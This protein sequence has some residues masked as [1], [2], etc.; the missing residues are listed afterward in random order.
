[1]PLNEE[2]IINN[3]YIFISYS[4][5][6]ADA[7]REDATALMAKGVRVWYDEHMRIGE[8]WS[9]IAEKRINDENCVG[10]LFYNSPNAFISKAVQEEQEM[11]SVRAKNGEFHIW[12]VHLDAKP[13]P[14]ICIEAISLHPH[15]QEYFTTAMPFQQ[16]MFDDR[17]LCIM[18]TDS[19][20]TVDRIYNEIAE[21][22]HVVDNENNLMD[23]AR[24]SR[25]SMSETNEIT[26]GRYISSE[27]YGPEQPIGT[28]DQRFGSQKTLILLNGKPYNTK[29]LRWQLMYVK[30]ERA[31]L[32]CSRIIDRREFTDGLRF[33]SSTFPT[34]AFADIEG[35]ESI[36]ARY[37]TSGDV[38]LAGDRHTESALSLSECGE[39]IHWW[40][41]ENGLTDHWKKTYSNDFLYQKGFPIFIKKG[42][43]PIIEVPVKL[44]QK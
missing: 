9:D 30:D 4:H 40:I 44:F 16:K 26:L 38:A 24:K 29:E 6:D 2:K 3:K 20:S 42:I 32:L 12:A 8:K 21:P 1:M 17:V 22:Y 5:R 35:A 27:Y 23:D 18:R 28:E 25:R 11:A 15:V 33:L 41:D 10:V 43:R 14:Q 13:T 34:V 37:L 39:N 7:V 36:K 19:E 31:V